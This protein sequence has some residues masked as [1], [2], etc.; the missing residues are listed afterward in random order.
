[1]KRPFLS[2]LCLLASW[3]AFAQS[4]TSLVVENTA[5]LLADEGFAN[6]R[7]VETE[8]FT[9]FTIENDRFKIPAEGFAYAARLI[10]SAGLDTS[11][12][13]KVI[14]TAQALDRLPVE[15]GGTIASHQSSLPRR[16]A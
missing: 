15:D 10:E 16:F 7:A 2:L 4:E 11:K 14:G 3:A 6:V 1:M 5:Q 8:D 9:V 13:V 12:P